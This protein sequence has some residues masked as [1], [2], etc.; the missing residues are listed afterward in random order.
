MLTQVGG[1]LSKDGRIIVVGDS[2]QWLRRS[3]IT[4]EQV[5]SWASYVDEL[6]VRVC[7]M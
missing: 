2:L 5:K 3:W 4:S 1:H 6:V 7:V